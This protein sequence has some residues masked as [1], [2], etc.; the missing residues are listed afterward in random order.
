M[1]LVIFGLVGCSSH[2]GK[3][4]YRSDI[5]AQFEDYMVLPDHK[6]YYSGSAARP[7][8]ILG[9]HKDFTLISDLWNPVDLTEDKLKNWVAFKGDKETYFKNNNGA[10]ILTKDGEHIG[11][12]YANIN[13]KDHAFVKMIDDKTVNISTP[14]AAQNQVSFGLWRSIADIE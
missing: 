4:D 12:W 9:V 2:Y 6:Y 3:F 8:A 13:R 11:V 14:F 5:E 1:F 7:R 10:E